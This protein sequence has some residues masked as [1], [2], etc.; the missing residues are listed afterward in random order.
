M[1][2]HLVITTANDHKAMRDSVACSLETLYDDGNELSPMAEDY[3]A[4]FDMLSV[5]VAFPH[6]FDLYGVLSGEQQDLLSEVIQDCIRLDSSFS[7]YVV[8]H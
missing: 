3:E 1:S 8:H 5:S 7:T 2:P 4:I 6:T